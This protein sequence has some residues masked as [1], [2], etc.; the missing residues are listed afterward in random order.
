M[1]EKRAISTAPVFDTLKKVFGFQSFRPNQEEIVKNILDR[2][3]VF[4]VMPTGGGKS[5]CYQ[6][7]A[8][9]MKGTTVVISPL[10]SLMKD[11]VDAAVEDGISAAFM[12]S[13]LSPSQTSNVYRRLK[14]NSLDL[15][16]IAP[17]RFAMTG[18][19][20]TLK[21]MPLSL[22]AI[23]E[24]HCIS[25]WGHDF[26]PDYLGLS[27]ILET[28]PKV[29]VAAFTATATEKVQNDI[30]NKLNLR[31]PFTVRA[32]FDRPNLIYRV[33][34]KRGL[35]KQLLEFLQN[36]AG[37]SGIIYRTTRDSVTGLAEM[38]S[39][40]G[41]KALPYHAGLT[42]E[43]RKVNQ[44]A[45]NRDEV[46]VIVATIAFGM[47]IDK[48]NVRF[49]VH[50]DLPKNIEG[51]YQETGRAG[52]DG[53]P[54]ECVLYFGRGDIPKIRY[55]IDQAP[56]ESERRIA[57]EKLNQ[58]VKYASHNV[59]R[60]RQLLEYFG[61]KY[62]DKNCG[63]CDICTGTVEKVNITIDAQKIMSA[64]SRTGQRFGIMHIIDIIA[65]ADTKR[66]RDLE[67]DKIKTYGVG[68]G[69]KKNHWHFV[70][71]ELLA[72]EAI[73][74]D[75]DKY[76]VLI[77]SDKGKR[78]LFGKEEISAL[79]REEP[80]DKKRAARRS[81]FGPYDEKLFDRLRD[82]RK[83]LADDQ[84]VP[85]YIIFS[86][87][88]LH[89][90]CRSF[91]ATPTTMTGV[92]GVGDSK[93]KRYG[94]E[95][96]SVIK[97]YLEENPDIKRNVERL[98]SDVGRRNPTNELPDNIPVRTSVR[99]KSR[100]IEETYKLFTHGH[101]IE[102]IAKTRNL[103]L[104]TVEAHIEKLIMEGRDI[105]IDSLIPANKRDAVGKLFITRQSWKLTP[106][107]EHFKGSVSYTEA[108]VARAYLRRQTS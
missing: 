89:E 26:R 107:I 88:T 97:K 37:E 7:P 22:F 63:S 4:A 3:D 67:H 91:P 20:E 106:V 94:D 73:I 19:L 78:V 18:F 59:C 33:D 38:L 85:P 16:Y 11:Q 10:I 66:I 102:E 44:E 52:R 76:P 5:L 80:R 58:M 100:T 27:N 39:V 79:R 82:L 31:S 43:E 42:Q 29:P 32:S 62:Q 35:E 108:K 60:R 47:G 49:V 84:Q 14:D 13:S 93:L 23:D 75:G 71:D 101:S 51:Y 55:F 34:R 40:N 99:K 45:F 68:S 105:D 104:L 8:K 12:N 92:S 30:I 87:R 81:E 28:F 24:A 64:I 77:L 15:L 74:Q 65:G 96:I 61:E 57:I 95:F 9:I 86:D 36:N 1:G 48:S 54:A 70:V 69:K 17:E 83:K 50:A 41:I 6:L 56:E 90:M 98:A 72:Q 53:E 21:S 25:E 2:K 103:S 46:N